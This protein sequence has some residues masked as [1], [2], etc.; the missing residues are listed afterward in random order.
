[1]CDVFKGGILQ[2]NV[3]MTFLMHGQNRYARHLDE[4]SRDC[5]Q[6][7]YTK[8]LSQSEAHVAMCK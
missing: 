2:R 3:H 5:K 1:M 8:V 7:I 6:R 4:K